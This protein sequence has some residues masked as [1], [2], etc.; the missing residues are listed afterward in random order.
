MRL[1]EFNINNKLVQFPVFV[2][3][4][5][6]IKTNYHPLD[7]LKLLVKIKYPY[8]LI[9]AYDICY[10]FSKLKNELSELL[11]EANKNGQIIF[12]DS[13]NYE[14][15]WNKFNPWY[16]D[17][18]FRK[19]K[20]LKVDFSFSFDGKDEQKKEDEKNFKSVLLQ[21]EFAGNSIV[22]PIMQNNDGRS[23]EEVALSYAKKLNPTILAIPERILGNG[24]INRAKALKK[25]RDK[26]D[27]F[28]KE[29]LIHLLGTGNPRSILIYIFAGADCFDGL[30]WCQTAVEPNSG[31]LYHFQQ[32]DLF[33]ELNNTEV[34]Y[35]TNTL[36]N[37]L[38]YYNSFINEIH[39]SIRDNKFD[40]ILSK[41]FK[42]EFM[43]KLKAELN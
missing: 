14:F 15:F 4:I 39:D 8:L 29:I 10:S 31:L 3:S 33:L 13:G 16:E 20:K 9:S 37:N 26:I 40:K 21:E 19:L 32:T 1:N 34:D 24:I 25:I 27:T 7:Y 17:L 12:L 43:E 38:N 30:E 2:P 18:Y 11:D 41:Y 22:V 36:I 35:T 6:T 28:N 42:N 23:L 5:S